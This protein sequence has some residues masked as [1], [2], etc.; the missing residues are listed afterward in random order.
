MNLGGKDT[1]HPITLGWPPVILTLVSGKQNT[2]LALNKPQC[3]LTWWAGSGVR[4]QLQTSQMVLTWVSHIARDWLVA[5]SSGLALA[6]TIG[7]TGPSSLCLLFLQFSVMISFLKPW[8]RAT[9]SESRVQA[10]HGKP[11]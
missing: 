2:S 8:Q 9:Q 11:C 5:D 1:V 10:Q 7:K 3:P 4:G 6:G